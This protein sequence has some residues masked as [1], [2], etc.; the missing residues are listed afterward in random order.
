MSAP[1]EDFRS[2]LDDFDLEL[3]DVIDH[4][5]AFRARRRL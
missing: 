4:D 1:V 2:L 5:T 3:P